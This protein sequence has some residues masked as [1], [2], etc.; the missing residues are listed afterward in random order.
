MGWKER[1]AL[2]CYWGGA[3]KL[4][5]IIT[6]VTCLI[7]HV[8]FFA[9]A[10]PTFLTGAKVS[11]SFWANV[12]IYIVAQLA[13]FSISLIG[14]ISDSKFLLMLGCY[15]EPSCL[16]IGLGIAVVL[17]VICHIHDYSKSHLIPCS[18]GYWFFRPY[19]SISGSL[20]YCN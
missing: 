2:F 20:V 3:V 18:M 5:S 7:V 4:G 12:M 15:A 8:I 17:L 11:C 6:L 19:R 14:T 9:Q 16:V 13:V 1:I 10:L